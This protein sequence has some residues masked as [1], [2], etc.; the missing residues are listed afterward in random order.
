[1]RSA[2]IRGLVFGLLALGGLA[3][4]AAMAGAQLGPIDTV[5]SI[6][7]SVT[8]QTTV[9][10]DVT[11]A[12][13]GVL[14]SATGEATSSEPGTVA[15]PAAESRSGSGSS[16]DSSPRPA[17]KS[18]PGSRHTRFDRLPR[19]Y[20]RLLERIEA[21]R[22]VEA[23]TRRLRVLLASA[24]PAMRARVLRLIR[25]EI[26]R[27]E[28]GGLTR[29]EQGSVER[30]RALRSALE[31]GAASRHAGPSP[32]DR[33]FV[34]SAARDAAAEAARTASASGHVEERTGGRGAFPSLRSLPP[35]PLPS[36][37]DPSYWILFLLAAIAFLPLVILAAT[38]ERLP[39]LVRGLAEARGAA[40]LSAVVVA[41]GFALAFALCVVLLLQ[42]L[43]PA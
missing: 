8:S 1:M 27:L 10:S 6:V 12:A 38:R 31:P 3:S 35:S 33:G 16:A 4:G 14:S 25:R 43:V 22:N 30:L 34:S 7:G 37:G 20:E 24:S 41:V 13:G 28:Q 18:N 5:T 42:A 2:A 23:N 9:A 21:G 32:L 11:G 19:R 17:K 40:H 26:A 15:G 36:T 39:S 29:R